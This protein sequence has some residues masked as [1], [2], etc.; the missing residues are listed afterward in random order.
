MR[1]DIAEWI[2]DME[3]GDVLEYAVD[4]GIFSESNLEDRDINDVRDD[5]IDTTYSEY[6]SQLDYVDYMDVNYGEE[7]MNRI[8]GNHLDLDSFAEW[9]VGEDGIAHF[10]VRYDGRKIE[11]PNYLYA[12]RID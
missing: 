12:Y 10:L 11:L 9:A 5:V 8:I 2:Y 6:E 7:E 4:N 3:D 1:D